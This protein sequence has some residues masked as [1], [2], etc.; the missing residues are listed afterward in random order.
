[1][2]LDET[3]VDET[4]VDEKE[5]DEVDINPKNCWVITNVKMQLPSFSYYALKVGFWFL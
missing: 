4:V 5:V 3:A 2:T 1:M